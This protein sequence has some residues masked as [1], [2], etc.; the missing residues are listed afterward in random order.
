MQ[1]LSSILQFQA[2]YL[3]Q[4]GGKNHSDFLARALP[5]IVSD[6]VCCFTNWSG[7][8]IAAGSVD[9]DG[10]EISREFKKTF[11]NLTKVVQM[12]C[13]KFKL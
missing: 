2:S 13:G 4:L 3:S 7:S 9:L 1:F 8:K 12:F 10:I 11:A 5:K 6:F